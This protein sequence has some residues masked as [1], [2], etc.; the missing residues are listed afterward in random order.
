MIVVEGWRRQWGQK[1]KAGGVWIIATSCGWIEVT[2]YCI[3][4]DICQCESKEHIFIHYLRLESSSL[5]LRIKSDLRLTESLTPQKPTK[6]NKSETP[7]GFFVGILN[8]FRCVTLLH[9]SFFN[10]VAIQTPPLP[11]SRNFLQLLGS[12]LTQS[13][14][15][16]WLLSSRGSPS[17]RYV[18][19]DFKWR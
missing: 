13:D 3:V 15:I 4:P 18:Y 1:L 11:T 2:W 12:R 7:T 17:L 19:C 14:W 9:T 10:W 6:T 16:N 5:P 8:T